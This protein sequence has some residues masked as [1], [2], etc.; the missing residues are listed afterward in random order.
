M[1]VG[2]SILAASTFSKSHSGL[3]S[4]H[5]FSCTCSLLNLLVKCSPC[6]CIVIIHLY[7]FNQYFGCFLFPRF[8]R[9][10]YDDEQ[11]NRY[12]VQLCNMLKI[13]HQGSFAQH[14]FKT[15]FSSCCFHV[16]MLFIFA[17]LRIS[18]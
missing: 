14:L 6:S 4:T 10:H 18:S 8:N 12:H 2:I 13:H 7:N 11:H 16:G 3:Y 17:A 1:F 15:L 5:P 9:C